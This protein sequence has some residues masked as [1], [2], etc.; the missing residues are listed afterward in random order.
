[1]YA[2]KESDEI[3]AYKAWLSIQDNSDIDNRNPPSPTN[4]KVIDLP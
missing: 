3:T 4:T 1:M 2:D